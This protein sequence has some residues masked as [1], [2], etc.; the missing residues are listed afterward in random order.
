MEFQTFEWS[1]GIQ[2]LF[3]ICLLLIHLAHA[4]LLQKHYQQFLLIEV[5]NYFM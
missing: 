1:F 2:I 5:N 4:A 3:Q